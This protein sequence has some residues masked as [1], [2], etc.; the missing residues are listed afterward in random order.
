MILL[1]TH[2]GDTG[3]RAAVA[4]CALALSAAVLGGGQA[5]ASL[6]PDGGAGI[7]TTIAGGVGNQT[8][9]TKVAIGACGLTSSSAG[10][11]LPGAG[12]VQL[13]NPVT[14]FLSTPVGGQ[15]EQTRGQPYG[16]GGPAAYASLD[17]PCAAAVDHAGNLLI[18]DTFHNLLRVVAHTSGT[19]YGQAMTAGHIYLVAGDGYQGVTAN[20]AQATKTPLQSPQGVAVD[21]AGNVVIT[22]HN[23]YVHVLA[24]NTGTYYG[25]PM[26]AGDLYNV[27]GGGTTLGDGGPATEAS[28]DAPE[29]VAVDSHGNL[30]IV[31]SL[32]ERVRVV[33]ETDGTFYGVAMTAGDIYAV[34][35]NGIGGYSGDG[36]PATSAELN[37]PDGVAVDAGGN[38]LLSDTG[39]NRVRVVA[40]SNGTFYGQAMTAG[41]IYT[42]AGNGTAGFTGDG[43]PAASAE[44]LDPGSLSVDSAGNLLVL[45]NDRVRMIPASSGTFFNQAMSAGDIYS[46]AGNGKAYSGNRGLAKSA[47]LFDPYGVAVDSRG[48]L[49]IANTLANEIW[50]SAH[51]P[52][53][54]YGVTM[55][56]GHIYDVAGDGQ[57]GSSGSGGPATKASLDTPGGVAVDSHGNLII[58]GAA[59]NEAQVVAGATG[60]F[61]GIAMTAGNIYTIAGTGVG[62]FSGD[63]GPAT[64]A[65]L[66]YPE[67]VGVDA[68]GNLLLADSFNSRV[69]VVA[70]TSGMFYGQ[71]MTAGHIYTIAGNGTAGF[72]GDGA[73][74]TSAEL[75]YPSAVAV[76]SHGNVLIADLRNDRIRV[77]AATSGMFYGQSMTAGN[78]Y[79][80]AGGGDSGLGDGGP[81]TSAELSNPQG[82]TVDAAGNVLIAD[83]GHS[84]VRVVAQSNGTFYGVAM[85]AG[86]IYTVAGNGHLGYYGDDRLGINA[87][88]CD[89]VGVAPDGSNL[90]IGD[91][92]NDRVREVTG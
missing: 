92:C 71:A 84:R 27:A 13:V 79:T 78:I 54:F 58:A 85:T 40:A 59:S 72:S 30:L 53:E 77:V 45:C 76:D 4:V 81:A 28:L 50:V 47:V 69:R 25:Q 61:Y 74:A 9:A 88:L 51:A 75:Y 89:P 49:I 1:R 86:N 48:N 90:I 29:G 41:H 80:V 16:D 8:R 10:L 60:M 14:G 67:G 31:D 3:R 62:G 43:G 19:Y 15:P 37:L 33:A 17:N 44:L 83:S 22:S 12:K 70:A 56:A 57:R 38:L 73:P 32:D 63:G 34:A 5:H 42:I 2:K 52:G 36:G 64:S 21:A 55:T 11:Y 46:I 20:G 35:G 18:A 7:I 87:E 24:E 68:A 39:N 23:G 66:D 6:R 82:V 26:T 65:E 91:S